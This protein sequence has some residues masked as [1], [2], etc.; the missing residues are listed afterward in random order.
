[1][2]INEVISHLT[3]IIDNLKISKDINE[4]LKQNLSK[5]KRNMYLRQKLEAINNELY[6]TPVDEKSE[7]E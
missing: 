5:E 4:K 1:M 3:R 7:I 6:G 2:L